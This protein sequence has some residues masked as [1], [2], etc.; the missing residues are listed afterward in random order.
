MSRCIVSAGGEKGFGA[1]SCVRARLGRVLVVFVGPGRRSQSAAGRQCVLGTAATEAG[2]RR[3]LG[4]TATM[5]GRRCVLRS[6]A[7][8]TQPQLSARRPAVTSRAPGDLGRKRCRSVIQRATATAARLASDAQRSA[9]QAAAVIASIAI[10]LQLRNHVA[11][12]F[13]SRLRGSIAGDHRLLRRRFFAAGGTY[14]VKNP[15]SSSYNGLDRA[16]RRFAPRRIPR[17]L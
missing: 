16:G 12:G 1:L 11:S 14:R 8:Y 7:G 6:T 15:Q 9:R 10:L 4:T 13:A 3:V 2:H 17:V 5:S